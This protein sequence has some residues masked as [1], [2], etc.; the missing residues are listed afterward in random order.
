MKQYPFD[1]SYINN[2]ICFASKYLKQTFEKRHITSSPSNM[3]LCC[4]ALLLC[5]KHLSNT[6]RQETFEKSHMKPGLS[7]V[8]LRC[9]GFLTTSSRWISKKFKTRFRKKSYEIRSIKYSHEMQYLLNPH[10]QETFEKSLMKSGLSNM[11]FIG[12]IY[13]TWFI[14]RQSGMFKRDLRQN[15]D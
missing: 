10:Q 4:N 13:E 6:V 11:V 8:L 7:N 5:M 1:K 2:V 15:S 9:T 12:N 3:F 14:G